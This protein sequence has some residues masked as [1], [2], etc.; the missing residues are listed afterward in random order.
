MRPRMDPDK[1]NIFAVSASAWHRYRGFLALILQRYE[2]TGDDYATVSDRLKTLFQGT[3][4]EP[5][6]EVAEELI[7]TARIQERLHLEIESFYIFAKILLDRIADTFGYYFGTPWKRPG[8]T[9]SQ[10]TSSFPSLRVEKAFIVEPAE[11]LGMLEELK[12]MIVDYRTGVIEH[13]S[14]PRLIRGTSVGPDKAPAIVT[15]ILYPV[16]SEAA[17]KQHE[18]VDPRALLRRLDAYIDAIM[19]FLEVNVDRSIVL[20]T[21]S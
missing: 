11:L 12:R 2:Q 7:R 8:S 15:A 20:A 16:G 14:E 17:E 3:S 19:T 6:Q 1:G 13:T 9:H 10:L 21:D 5:S 4:R 18:T